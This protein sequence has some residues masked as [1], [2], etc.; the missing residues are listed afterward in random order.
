MV[1]KGNLVGVIS[2][3]DVLAITPE[4]IEMVQE[5]S[6]IEAG[7]VTDVIESPPMAGYCDRCG[8]WSSRLKEVEGEFL[9]D[10][11]NS[12]NNETF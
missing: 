3:K 4:L 1:Y 10:E 5:K 2:A 9:C 7:S 11:C 8:Q 12:E 6:R